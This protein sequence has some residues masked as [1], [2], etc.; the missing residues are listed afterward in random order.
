MVQSEK[1]IAQAKCCPLCGKVNSCAVALG[2]EAS[3]CWCMRADI[4][5]AQLS[6][7]L[8]E[9]APKTNAHAYCVCTSCLEKIGV[10]RPN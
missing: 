10:I 1:E 6:Q 8:S 3:T 2:V 9:I 5:L 7:K 4:D